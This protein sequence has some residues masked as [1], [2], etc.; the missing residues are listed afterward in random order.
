MSGTECATINYVLI[1]KSPSYTLQMLEE[2]YGSSD[3]NSSINFLM[4][5]M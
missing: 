3:R 5:A 1:H 4:M 2:A